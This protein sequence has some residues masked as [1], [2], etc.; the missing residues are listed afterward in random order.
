MIAGECG[1]VPV[2]SHVK[3]Y[4]ETFSHQDE[5]KSE[6][7]KA[8]RLESSPSIAR[9]INDFVAEFGQIFDKRLR[10]FCYFCCAGVGE[11]GEERLSV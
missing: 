3:K 10:R 1:A 11:S 4:F 8:L 5:D 9:Y 7:V 6:C 2:D